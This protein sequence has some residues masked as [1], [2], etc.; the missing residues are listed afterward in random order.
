M[1]KQ[2]STAKALVKE[3]GAKLRANAV[4]PDA[5]LYIAI[6]HDICTLVTLKKYECAASMS[7]ALLKQLDS[8]AF[9]RLCQS[10]KTIF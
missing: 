9:C 8:E 1:N 4:H 3:V 2:K 7:E 5:M 10:K 6:Y